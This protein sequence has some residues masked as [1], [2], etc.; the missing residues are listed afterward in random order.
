MGP[1]RI[2]SGK[3]GVDMVEQ[4]PDKPNGKLKSATRVRCENLSQETRNHYGFPD[5]GMAVHEVWEVPKP[6]TERIDLAN[7]TNSLGPILKEE[8]KPKAKEMKE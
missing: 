5:S 8:Q 7:D 3:E 1:R 2:E 4:K 6:K